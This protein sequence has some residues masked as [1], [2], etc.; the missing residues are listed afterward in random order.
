MVY[1]LGKEGKIW[2]SRYSNNLTRI[3][4]KCL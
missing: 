4:K 2:R 1:M 3:K